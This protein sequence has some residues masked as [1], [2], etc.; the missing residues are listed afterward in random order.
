[1]AS[2]TKFD[3]VK[4]IEEIGGR[5]G[6]LRY[7]SADGVLYAYHDE[8]ADEH[9]IVSKGD[10]PRTRWTDRVPA[11]RTRVVPGEQLW[12][13][14]DNWEQRV[15]SKRDDHGKGLYYI[16]ETDVWV[17]VSIPTNNWLVDAWFGV[18]AVGDL[19]V[20][21]DGELPHRSAIR[22]QAD[23]VEERADGDEYTERLADALRTV[24]RNWQAVRKGYAIELEYLRD[25]RLAEHWSDGHALQVDRDWVYESQHYLFEPSRSIE[26][27]DLPDDVA[28]SDV[29][30]ELQY[31]DLL[32]S[33]YRITLG[34]DESAVGADYYDRAL[35]EA[36]C[37]P[38]EAL[39]YRKV[40]LDGLTQ[41]VWAKER[42]RDASTI[43]ENISNAERI[44]DASPSPP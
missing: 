31:A 21:V 43:S 41:A 25:E 12:T 40:E 24:A 32:P 11:E 22:R 10:E 44:L 16:P 13:I 9:V 2:E 34:I 35:I 4:T 15:Y 37:S 3:G 8:T 20:D 17:R 27:M 36:G 19:A 28:P 29:V 42:H 1:M 30:D 33:R 38:A 5:R 39:D 14:P 26:D 18:Q 6:A 7:Y 23:A